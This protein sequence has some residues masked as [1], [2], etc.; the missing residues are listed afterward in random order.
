MIVPPLI[1]QIGIFSL[2]DVFPSTCQMK[3]MTDKTHMIVSAAANMFARYG[4]SKTTMGDIANEA[5]VARQ[6]VYNAFPGKEE[7]LRAVV[8]QAGDETYSAVMASWADTDSIDDKLSAFHQ[9]GPL[10]WFEAICAAPDL[11]ELMDGLH[12]AASEEMTA[13]DLKW[14]AALTEMLQTS[15]A[16]RD[17]LPASIDDIVDFFYSASLN[18]KHGVQDLAQLRS[19]LA[20]IKLAT[21]ALL[22]A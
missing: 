21:L 22:K 19:R 7:I 9:Y 15:L 1:G 11:A 5:G 10:K 14:R 3:T 18:A 2:I 4:Y 8:R 13:L 20:T 12:R 16:A 17:G 6:T